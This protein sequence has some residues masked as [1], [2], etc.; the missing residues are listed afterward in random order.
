M[1]LNKIKTKIEKELGKKIFLDKSFK[2]NN[3]DSLDLITLISF[4]KDYNKIRIS[5]SKLKKIKNFIDL[6]KIL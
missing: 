3:F 5:E 1:R 2:D 6:E 4:I